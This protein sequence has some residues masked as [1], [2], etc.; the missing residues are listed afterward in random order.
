MQKT[1]GRETN[2]D[3]LLFPSPFSA[4]SHHFFG[5]LTASLKMPPYLR[6]HTT[7]S[8]IAYAIY[9]PNVKPTSVRERKLESPKCSHAH[10]P[11]NPRVLV[12][13]PLPFHFVST[14]QFTDDHIDTCALRTLTYAHREHLGLSSFLSHTNVG[15]TFSVL[16]RFQSV[17]KLLLARRYQKSI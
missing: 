11:L 9:I 15:L 2:S 14:V 1:E 7:G 3:S 13:V 6:T 8:R 17:Q 5:T 12:H 4:P 16:F 10:V